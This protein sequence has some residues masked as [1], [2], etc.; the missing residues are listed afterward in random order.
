[1]SFLFAFSA[2]KLEKR[3]SFTFM[4]EVKHAS[5]KAVRNDSNAKITFQDC[6]ECNNDSPAPSDRNFT[7]IRDPNS[8]NVRLAIDYTVEGCV[9]TEETCH[10]DKSAHVFR[11]ILNFQT[12]KSFDFMR[13]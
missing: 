9:F 13:L 1:M 4:N 8:R 2:G 11:N 7:P 10:F 3:D 6:S 5:C 12:L